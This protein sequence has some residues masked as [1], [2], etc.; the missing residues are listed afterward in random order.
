MQTKLSEHF[1]LAEFACPHCKEVIAPPSELIEILEDIRAH[2]KAP[3]IIN[4]GYRCK[5]HNAKIGGASK[6][7]HLKGVAVDI[8]VKGI[9]TQDLFSYCAQKYQDTPIGLAGKVNY[10]N[11]YGGFVHIDARGVKARWTY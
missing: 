2:F 3:V 11:V 6:S 5:E 4:S 8:R 1:D 7:Y 10:N 9:K